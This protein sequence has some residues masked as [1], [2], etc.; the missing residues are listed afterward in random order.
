M[1]HPY[2][3]TAICL[4]IASSLAALT[5]SC[6]D[7]SK[8]AWSL[9]LRPTLLGSQKHLD[10]HRRR[11]AGALMYCPYRTLCQ[12]LISIV[13]DFVASSLPSVPPPGFGRSTL[14]MSRYLQPPYASTHVHT[15]T[16][17]CIQ[18]HVLPTYI[19]TYIYFKNEHVHVPGMQGS[20]LGSGSIFRI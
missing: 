16:H 12:S 14:C 17:A 6:Q 9:E 10:S 8:R 15:Y 20:L 11:L 7:S 13:H 19:H 4:P 5:A 18:T 2:I 1:D 3:E